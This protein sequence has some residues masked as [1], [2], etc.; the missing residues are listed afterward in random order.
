MDASSDISVS[1]QGELKKVARLILIGLGLAI[2]LLT[3]WLVAYRLPAGQADVRPPSKLAGLG[4]SGQIMGQEA[5]VDIE[6]LHGKQFPM[7]DG[8]VAYYADGLAIV[9][10]SSTWLPVMAERQVEL[11]TERIAEGRSPFEPLHTQQVEGVTVYVLSGMGQKHYYFQLD[12][13]VVW[14]AALPQFGELSLVE[15]IKALQ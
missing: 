2:L 8:V 3:G 7:T 12:R 6:R 9:W 11:M 1:K 15:L 13:R 14:L 10:I 4:I 5:L